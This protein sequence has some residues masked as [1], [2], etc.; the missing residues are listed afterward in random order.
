VFPALAGNPVVQGQDAT[1]MIHIVL[2]GATLPATASAPSTFSMPGFAWRL[3]DQQVA[4]V[5]NFIRSSWGNQAAAVTAGQVAA[6]RKAHAS[7]P[8]PRRDK[9]PR[10]RRPPR[11]RRSA[12]SVPRPSRRPPR[13]P[14]SSTRSSPS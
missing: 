8:G 10:P 9:R 7:W 2:E 11:R 1:S 4:D 3:S 14:R 13:K 12:R 5:V 6:L